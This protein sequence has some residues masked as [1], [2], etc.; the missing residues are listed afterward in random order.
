MRER[1]MQSAGRR[2]YGL[3]VQ[4]L[5]VEAKQDLDDLRSGGEMRRATRLA[6]L[7]GEELAAD[8]LPMYFTG[9]FD[10]ELVLVH[11]NPRLD[12]ERARTAAP[13]LDTYLDEHVR[14][15]H[16]TWGTDPDYRSAFD[17]K[18]VR[19]LRPF[20]LIEFV[21][22][23]SPAQ[24]RENA[25]RVIDEKLQLELVPYASRE[26]RTNRFQ[27]QLLAP[28]FERVLNVIADHPRQVVLFCGSVFDRL[29]ERS[30]LLLARRDHEFRLAKTDGTR[31]QGLYSFSNLLIDHHGMAIR[32]G[33]ARQFA[34]QGLPASAYG[35]RC[36]ELYSE[37][38]ER[39][40]GE[41]GSKF[42]CGA[43]ALE[44]MGVGDFRRSDQFHILRLA[45]QALG[46]DDSD[47]GSAV[48]RSIT[49][50]A[51]R[52]S[53]ERADVVHALNEGLDTDYQH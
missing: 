15:G 7:T 39:S 42:A 20:G 5:V 16:H 13:G 35:Q 25:K 32:A 43:E 48:E 37:P 46:E 50:F 4:Q 17:H 52:Y 12:P 9:R 51:R 49:Q 6:E 21:P 10:A 31:S 3:G 18:Q 41:G 23:E 1:G 19:F 8:V 2:S 27:P 34:M 22:N 24:K 14:Y 45:V 53:A 44:L 26:F 40:A 38:L 47:G 11:L 33:L 29:L 28:H 30:G 36:A